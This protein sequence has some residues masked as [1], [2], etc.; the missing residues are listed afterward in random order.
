MS[1]LAKL[2]TKKFISIS[3]LQLHRLQTTNSNFFQISETVDR[4]LAADD[5]PR[6]EDEGG[7]DVEAARDLR[8]GLQETEHDRSEFVRGRVHGL[9]PREPRLPQP[10][11]VERAEG[12]EVELED[13]RRRDRGRHAGQDLAQRHST[14]R[15]LHRQITLL[16]TSIR[17]A[18]KI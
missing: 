16:T 4:E 13:R 5:E 3:Y 11:V 10:P 12:R 7:D 1:N 8:Q 2:V 9:A 6:E 18:T 17:K 14:R 15:R